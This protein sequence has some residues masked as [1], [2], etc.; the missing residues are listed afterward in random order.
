MASGFVHAD[1]ADCEGSEESDIDQ[2]LRE[3]K[4]FKQLSQKFKEEDIGLDDIV[5]I[6]DYQTFCTE[7]G[8]TKSFEQARFIKAVK[9]LQSKASSTD[10][11]RSRVVI[12]EAE[13]K[14]MESATQQSKSIV[15]EIE[16][17]TALLNGI[18]NNYQKSEQQINDVFFSIINALRSRQKTLL[19]QLQGIKHGRMQTIEHVLTTTKEYQKACGD[20]DKKWDTLLDDDTLSRDERKNR[21]LIESADLVQKVKEIKLSNNN[22]LDSI[23]DT[24]ILKFGDYETFVSKFG[25]V[26]YIGQPSIVSTDIGANHVKLDVSVDGHQHEALCIYEVEY[27][28]RDSQDIADEMK[29]NWTST[30]KQYDTSP[31]LLTNLTHNTNYGIRCRIKANDICSGYSKIHWFQTEL[32]YTEQLPQE[33]WNV[34]RKRPQITVEDTIIF[35]NDNTHNRTW[36][37]IYGTEI[38]VTPFLYHWKLKIADTYGSFG[39]GWKIVVGVQSHNQTWDGDS[40]TFTCAKNGNSYGFNGYQAKLHSGRSSTTDYGIK[41]HQKGDTLD[42]YLDMKQHELSFGINNTKYGKAF[43]VAQ[44]KYTLA[45]SLCRGFK[46]EL[47]SCEKA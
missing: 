36:G 22:A 1:T 23:G 27:V 3:N 45:I 34:L 9:A 13:E 28:Q 14:A 20:M 5:I 8:L 31:V 29:M 11:K 24:F 32:Q 35:N 17:C 44:V 39:N 41:F 4:L 25:Y 38:C 46:I 6:T 43:S 19:S 40:D 42:V 30:K 33:K 47:L 7:F 26:G 37:T 10:K 12:T 15:E 2:W 18:K 16:R 21:I